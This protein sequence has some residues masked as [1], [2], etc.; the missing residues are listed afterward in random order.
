MSIA[1][2]GAVVNYNKGCTI[3]AL[4]HEQAKRLCWC[5]QEEIYNLSRLLRQLIEE[6]YPDNKQLLRVFEPPCMMTGRCMEGPG[7]CGRNIS[8]LLPVKEFFPAKKSL[9]F[10][11]FLHP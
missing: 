4:I 9:I 3:N 6:K 11:Y 7:Y 8:P 5:A 2:Y 10:T 1:P